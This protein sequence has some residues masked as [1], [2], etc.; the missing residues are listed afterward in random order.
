MSKRI[1]LIA[2]LKGS[3][4][5]AEQMPGCANYDHHYG[6][7][8]FGE[9]CKVEQGQRCVDFEKVLPTAVDIGA[10]ERMHFLYEKQCGLSVTLARG[11]MRICPNCGTELKPR[12]RFCDGCSKRRRRDSYR[13]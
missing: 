2:F 6:G 3:S 1:G 8:L 13:K 7:C 5:P 9:T 4:K 12:Q 11:Q 10:G